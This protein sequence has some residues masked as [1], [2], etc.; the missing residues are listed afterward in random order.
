MSVHSSKASGGQEVFLFVEKVDKTSIK[1]R[2]FDDHGWTADAKK[3]LVHHQVGIIINTPPY[4]N[5]HIEKAVDVFIQLYR[6][7][8]GCVSEPHRFTYYPVENHVHTKKR[9]MISQEIDCFQAIQNTFC[10]PQT[11]SDI[12][13]LDTNILNSYL[14]SQDQVRSGS[15][16]NLEH[17]IEQMRISYLPDLGSNLEFDSPHSV[18]NTSKENNQWA[19]NLYK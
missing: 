13:Q 14:S 11:F 10:P 12:D 4:K 5:L 2:F 6:T 18:S 9:R 8:D 17:D 16:W 1:V 7:T 3:E 19:N 15:H